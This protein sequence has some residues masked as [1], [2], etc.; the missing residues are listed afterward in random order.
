MSAAGDEVQEE[1]SSCPPPGG[2][3]FG[4]VVFRRASSQEQSG[5]STP[6]TFFDRQRAKFAGAT[7]SSRRLLTRQLQMSYGDLLQFHKV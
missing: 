5:H 1:V 2:G 3:L 6:A 4:L 7:D